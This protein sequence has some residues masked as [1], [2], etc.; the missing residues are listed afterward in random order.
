MDC[1]QW[2]L[3]WQCGINVLNTSLPLGPVVSFLGNYCKE[4][5]MYIVIYISLIEKRQR[6]PPTSMVKENSVNKL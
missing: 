2:R 4:T 5:E 6:K 3:F 1:Y